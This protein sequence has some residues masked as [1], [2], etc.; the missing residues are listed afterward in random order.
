MDLLTLPHYMYKDRVYGSRRDVIET[1]LLNK[2]YNGNITFHFGDSIFSK[3]DWSKSLDDISIDSLYKLRATQLREKYDYLAVSFSGGSDSTQI[4]QTFL[5]NNIFIDEIVCVNYDKLADSVDSSNFQKNKD[6]QQILEF[7]YAA[8]PILKKFKD[9]K[10]KISII[11]STDDIIEEYNGKQQSYKP[12]S[13][14]DGKEYTHHRG[15]P[16]R[17]M[18][19]IYSVFNHCNKNMPLGKKSALVRGFEKPILTID[20][21]INLKCFFADVIMVSSNHFH[22]TSYEIE[23][24]YWSCDV[25]FIPVKQCQIL[26]EA[27]EF[28][29][30]FC[31][32]FIKSKNKLKKHNDSYAYSPEVMIERKFSKYIYPDWNENTF[33]AAKLEK[34]PGELVA[35]KLL[36]L[37]D[38]IENVKKDIHKF[39]QNR[40]KL[41]LQNQEVNRTLYSKPYYLGKL[42]PKWR[43]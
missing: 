36:G 39:D 26:K 12:I 19:T 3:I 28:D 13:I 7:R 8:M 2:D 35:L 11:D 10:T 31:V 34:D 23:N 14:L 43:M 22:K 5:K 16:G 40:Y 18:Y 37:G 42:K 30:D 6:L 38:K 27:L 33:A 15:I 32:E 9:T 20:E 1:M 24:F 41:I 29:K 25:P 21:K 4:L 17:P